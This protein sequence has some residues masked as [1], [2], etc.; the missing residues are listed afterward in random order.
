MA[1]KRMFAKSI[2]ESD[3]FYDLPLSAQALYMHLCM[4]A[5]D[6]GFVGGVRKTARAV[7]VSEDDLQILRERRYILVFQ[8]GVAVIKHWKINNTIRK[9]RKTD[10]TYQEELELLGIDEKGAYTE[11]DKAKYTNQEY[12]NQMTTN[13]QPS[14]D[15]NRVCKYRVSTPVYEQ[16]SEVVK[17]YKDKTKEEIQA[18]FEKMV[19]KDESKTA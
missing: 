1:E 19:N 12:D 7:G 11:K 13:R 2:V 6:D 15:K 16:N 8:S 18:E 3:A 10:T 4:N 5:D 9:D 14:I 17:K